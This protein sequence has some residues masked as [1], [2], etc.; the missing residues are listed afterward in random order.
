MITTVNQV[1][2]FVNLV[3]QRSRSHGDDEVARK[4]DD[5]MHLGSSGL[6]VLGAIRSVILEERVTI[7]NLVGESDTEDVIRFV[8]KA[9]GQT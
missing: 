2:G 9:F 6:E 8:D 4:L 1:Y 5:A 3:I 7:N